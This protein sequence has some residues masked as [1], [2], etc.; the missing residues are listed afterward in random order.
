LRPGVGFLGFS[1]SLN[2]TIFEDTN[3]GR[4]SAL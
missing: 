3:V 1:D 2:K 4:L